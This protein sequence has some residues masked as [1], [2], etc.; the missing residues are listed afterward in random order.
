MLGDALTKD[1]T[2]AADLLSACVRASAYQH[3][4]RRL[5]VDPRRS[6]TSNEFVNSFEQRGM[7]VV[8]TAGKAKEQQ[9]QVER[10]TQMFAV[11]FEDVLTDVQ[12]RSTSGESVQ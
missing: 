7:E 5:K 3:L 6:Q 4:P 9:G 10:H 11:M 8:D 12:S 2:D 1:K